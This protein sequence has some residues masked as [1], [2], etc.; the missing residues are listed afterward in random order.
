MV[1]WENSG[2]RLIVDSSSSVESGG[3]WHVVD[4]GRVV[5]AAILGVARATDCPRPA[6]GIRTTLSIAASVS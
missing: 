1:L 6:L 2:S 5:P 4:D 3:E